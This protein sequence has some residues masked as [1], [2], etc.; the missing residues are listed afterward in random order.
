[1]V[2]GVGE[3]R[4]FVCVHNKCIECLVPFQ[5]KGQEDFDDS[6]QVGQIFRRSA[7]SDLEIDWTELQRVLNACFQ[8]GNR[9]SLYKII[10]SSLNNCQS[11]VIN[12]NMFFYE[13][14]VYLIITLT[15]YLMN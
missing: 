13:T 15:E 3:R 12:A 2:P 6:S 14:N 4:D 10:K 1:M 11:D 9:L 7:G 5:V 8:S